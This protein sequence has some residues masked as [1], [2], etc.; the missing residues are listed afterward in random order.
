MIDWNYVFS[1]FL[2]LVLIFNFRYL[3]KLNSKIKEFEIE[4]AKNTID[5]T[6]KVNKETHKIQFDNI[7]SS[8]ID[9]KS[10]MKELFEIMRNTQ[11][12]ISRINGKYT[13]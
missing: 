6:N 4:Q 2:L 3:F 7:N 12:E 1:G 8:L 10:D 5:I 11:S 13:K 9:L